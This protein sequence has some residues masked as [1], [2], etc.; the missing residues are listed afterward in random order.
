[1]KN[2]SSKSILRFRG[3]GR[4]RWQRLLT[5]W[6]W[7]LARQTER[8]EAIA[9]GVAV[10]VFAGI[11]PMLGQSFVA[12]A[13]AWLVRGSKVIAAAMT[14]I[15]NPVTTFPIFLFDYWLGCYLLDQKMLSLKPSDIESWE[16]F[17]SLGYD[18][19]IAIFLGGIITGAVAGGIS[20]VIGH[21]LVLRLKKERT[22]RSRALPAPM[23]TDALD[24]AN[25][26]KRRVG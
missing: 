5:Y 7:R 25:G 23:P 9:R 18:F 21:A 8:P 14:F 24:T 20:Y 4:P 16:S 11:L 2:C 19:V 12:I 1:M 22:Q 3:R 26:I 17:S 13:L 15:S 6:L 10:G